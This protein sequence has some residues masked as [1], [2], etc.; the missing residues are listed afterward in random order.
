MTPFLSEVFVMEFYK[1]GTCGSLI[2]KE[3]GKTYI[4]PDSEAHKFKTLKQDHE[5]LQ[6]DFKRLLESYNE[7]KEGKH[8]SDDVNTDDDDDG[9]DEGDDES[10]TVI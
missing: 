5:K 3:N 9:D 6:Q 7:L 8:V 1:C 4:D 10:G 2:N